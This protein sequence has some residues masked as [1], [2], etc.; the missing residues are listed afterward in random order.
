MKRT[1]IVCANCGGHLGEWLFER[2]LAVKRF[3]GMI[4]NLRT[5]NIAGHVFKGEGFGHP[6]VRLSG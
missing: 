2:F 4:R 5:V 6:K 1:E 3:P